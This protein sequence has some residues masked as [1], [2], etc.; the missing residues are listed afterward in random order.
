MQTVSQRVR[1]AYLK[2]C[3]AG[4]E[5]DMAQRIMFSTLPFLADPAQVALTEGVV[6]TQA[7]KAAVVGRK[8]I[9]KYG[10]LAVLGEMAHYQEHQHHQS[11]GIKSEPYIDCK[12]AIQQGDPVKAMDIA[13]AAFQEPESWFTHFGGRA[14]EMIARTIRQIARLDRQLTIVRESARSET[15]DKQELQLMRDLIVEMNVFDGLAHN[16]DSILNNI[17][18]LE[19]DSELPNA[20]PQERQKRYKENYTKL[21]RLMD[22][23][24][25]DSPVEVYKLIQDTLSGSGDIYKFKDWVTKMRTHKEYR[26]T[27]PK[28]G[29]KLFFIYLRKALLPARSEMNATRD[30][31][32]KHI[33]NLEQAWNLKDFFKFSELAEIK[34][35]SALIIAQEFEEH[36][37]TFLK[38]Y[39]ELPKED[40]EVEIKKLSERALVSYGVIKAQLN[41]F[42]PLQLKVELSSNFRSNVSEEL[43][44]A[45]VAK[46]KAILSA[47]NQFSYLLDAI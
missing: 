14:W 8:N 42:R 18:E 20:K 44:I 47:F 29:Y 33:S 28:L 46:Y 22:V 17:A 4:L 40:V 2:L 6:D 5:Q 37:N 26:Q 24:E 13:V 41:E 19:A 12:M 15:N 25:L 39:N 43:Q 35:D 36:G 31:L 34:C 27:D 38:Q 16:S 1:T 21:K 11:K 10:V 3:Y 7:L 32:S 9:I 23:K 30:R 45:L